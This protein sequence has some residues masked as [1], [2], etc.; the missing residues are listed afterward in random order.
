MY[1]DLQRVLE[2]F[3]GGEV[4]GREEW[5]SALSTVK[6]KNMRRSQFTREIA[7]GGTQLRSDDRGST[8]G[9]GKR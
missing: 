8:A 2:T 1:R 4:A 7:Q 6:I 3:P 9:R 5:S